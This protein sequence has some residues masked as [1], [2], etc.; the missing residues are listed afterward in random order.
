MVVAPRLEELGNVPMV[1]AEMPLNQEVQTDDDWPDVDAWTLEQM[2]Q[3][4]RSLIRLIE[5]E[6]RQLVC[7]DFENEIGCE[8][9]C[10]I[11]P[12]GG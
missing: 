2:R 11:D 8:S 3:R 9:A 5:G 10:N 1:A 12:V 4:L 6:E 7:T